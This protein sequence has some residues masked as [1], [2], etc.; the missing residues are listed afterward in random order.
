MIEAQTPRIIEGWISQCV[1]AL[2]ELL[3]FR[4]EICMAIIAVSSS[5][6]S[7]YSQRPFLRVSSKFNESAPLLYK[8]LIWPFLSNIN[9]SLTIKSGLCTLPG[10]V[11]KRTSL[12]EMSRTMEISFGISER[13]LRSLMLLTR[14]SGF[15]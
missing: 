10:S 4:S 14:S 12:F 13:R 11:K 5:S 3:C 15:V 2:N 1:Y 9:P 8:L 6:T 7:R